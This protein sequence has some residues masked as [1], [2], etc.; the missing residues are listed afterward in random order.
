MSAG[1]RTARAMG[2]ASCHD[3]GRLGPIEEAH[4]VCPRCGGHVHLRKPD[5]LNRAWALLIASAILYLPANL[6]PITRTEALGN[7]Q[8]DTIMSG[9]IYFLHHGDW[10]LA[11]VIF[12][13][14]VAVPFM[15]ILVLTFL[16]WTTQRGSTWRPLD[17]T[18][19]YRLTELVGRW[20]M[21]DVYV[22]TILVALVQ[23]GLLAQIKAG[24]GAIY[25]AFVV[26]LTMLAAEAYDPRLI[27]DPVDDRYVGKPPSPEERT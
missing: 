26:V 3:C 24:P 18:R 21:V 15:K 7:V 5:S 20:S 22:V 14:S 2:L 11:L 1:A 27:W 4:D 8:S 13:A 16:L 12:T 19:L 9:V 25:F 23:L 10:P 17:R 6:L